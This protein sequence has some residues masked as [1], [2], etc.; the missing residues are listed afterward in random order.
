MV[1]KNKKEK[2]NSYG[3]SKLRSFVSFFFK[4]TTENAKNTKKD[5]SPTEPED[6]MIA[7]AKHF[8]SKVR[9]I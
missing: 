1:D 4:T 5:A 2:K 3:T 7:A 8:S 6:T 9:L